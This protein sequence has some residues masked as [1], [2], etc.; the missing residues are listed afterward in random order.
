VS[1]HPTNILYVAN[2]GR[3]GGGNKV[4]MDLITNLDSASFAPV[5]V[6]PAPGPLAD[7]A[8]TQG[9]PWIVS[10]SRD[11]SGTVGLAGRSMRLAQTIRRFGTPIVHAGA[12]MA[13]RA[14]GLAGL[15]T[16]AIRICH[17]GFPPEPGELERAFV[18]GPNAVVA[19]YRQQ[20]DENRARIA[21]V[22]PGCGV[23][24]IPNGVDT[25]RFAPGDAP[26][27][28]RALRGNSELLIAILGHISEVKGY[29]TFIEA[30]ARLSSLHPE[31]RFVAIGGEMAEPGAR[32]RLEAQIAQTA[33][34]D[35]FQFLGYRQ[36]VAAILRAV[37]VVAV[38]SR[39]EGF[40]LAVLEAM[41]T[42]CAV[43]ATPVGGVPEVLLDDQTGLLVKPADAESLTAALCRLVRS[44]ALR[45]RLGTAARDMV[46]SR[47]SI[48]TFANAIQKL[49]SGLLAAPRSRF[50][51]RPR[52]AL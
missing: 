43:V 14:A 31:C 19:C 34:R 32:S 47:Y 29:P 39:A 17:L 4:L 1:Q 13:Y 6:V 49:Y 35:R 2:A 27:E 45:R 36:D 48:S 37:D 9:V 38:P 8:R 40:P 51:L 46:E 50:R 26:P 12:P 41:A 23:V 22:A 3:I 25:R 24:A 7:W 21:A 16:G 33:L 30:A 10:P 42:G 44:A 20:A 5:V 52:V 18:A 11:W 28:A 15:L